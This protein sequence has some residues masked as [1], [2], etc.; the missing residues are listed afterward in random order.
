[1]DYYSDKTAKIKVL[2]LG[3]TGAMGTQLIDI[4]SEKNSC[5]IFY[6][7]RQQRIENRDHVT[8]LTG[9]A[10][11][12]AFLTKL[13]ETRWDVIVDFMVY[14]TQE[15]K[16][17][18][19]RLLAAT[20]QYVFISSARVFAD[21]DEWITERSPRLLDVC[22]DAEYLAT[23]EYALAKAR[24]ENELFSRKREGKKNWTIVRPSLT[25]SGQRLQ[26][27]VYEKETWLKRALLRDQIVF[28]KDLMEHYYTM[29]TGYDVARG[30]AALLCREGALGE[31]FNIVTMQP[32]KWKDILEIYLDT[33]EACSGKRP[34]VILTEKCSNLQLPG[35]RYQ[36]IY[37]RY[38]DRKFDNGKI[39]EFIDTSTFKNPEEGLRECLTE[40]LAHPSFGSCNWALEGMIDRELGQKINL[41]EITGRKDKAKYFI[42]RYGLDGIA[43]AAKRLAYFIVGS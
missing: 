25:Y 7:S 8:C 12:D 10:Q 21:K 41:R 5:E 28:S 34:E 3:G 33:L 16:N 11:E 17:R 23:D 18:V 14:T 15:F 43:R 40:F 42:Y 39:S 29:T 27:G 36:V 26:L 30:I 31:D 9:N 38:F 32:R 24:Q 1:M 35:A 22:E 37:G 19:D 2:I 6:T 20:N 4:L 13:L